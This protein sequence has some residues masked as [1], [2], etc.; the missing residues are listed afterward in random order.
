M[1]SNSNTLSL[2]FYVTCYC[3]KQVTSKENMRINIIN[4]SLPCPV[5]LMLIYHIIY[6]VAVSFV[7]KLRLNL[8]N[9]GKLKD[10]LR[11]EENTNS[12]RLIH[13]HIP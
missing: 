11:L 2:V 1:T 10:I 4:F 13:S 7:P 9:S 12:C 3:I 5:N 8:S 6:I